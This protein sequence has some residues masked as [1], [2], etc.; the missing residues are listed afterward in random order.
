[1]KNFIRLTIFLSV[2]F[3]FACGNSQQNTAATNAVA[4]TDTLKTVAANQVENAPKTASGKSIEDLLKSGQKGIFQD[5]T[6][7]AM[8][9]NDFAVGVTSTV[10]GNDINSELTYK[11]TTYM[12]ENGVWKKI[13]E[14][15]ATSDSGND[16]EI[17][18][19]DMDKDGQKDIM[20]QL[21]A[22]GRGNQQYKLFLVKN[23]KLVEVR[24]FQDLLA[25][26]YDE[27]KKMISTTSSY[28]GGSTSE[29]YKLGKDT[30]I[31]VEGTKTVNDR[32]T[33]THTRNYTKKE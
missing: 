14:H 19:E 25:P 20:L 6:F 8:I 33:G 12:K 21:S 10:V 11:A 22:D 7:A 23:K 30:V 9:E 1:M 2:F 28:H 16:P 5:S 17:K 32:K 31:F 15:G 18:L 26:T 4:K 24:G 27:K 29:F 13:E 3:L